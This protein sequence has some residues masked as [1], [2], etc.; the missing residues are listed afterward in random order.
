LVRRKGVSRGSFDYTRRPAPRFAQDDNLGLA[1]R[2]IKSFMNFKNF[3]N[4]TN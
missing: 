1:P 2:Y 4:F 3:I